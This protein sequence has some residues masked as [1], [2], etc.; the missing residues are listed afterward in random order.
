MAKILAPNIAQNGGRPNKIVVRITRME[1]SEYNNKKKPLIIFY[2]FQETSFGKM[3]VAN[4]RKGICYMGFIGDKKKRTKELE[5]CFPKAL[6]KQ[7]VTQKQKDIIQ[8]FLR[9]WKCISKI[10]LHLKG[11]EFQIKVWKQ[12]LHIPVGKVT[13]YGD[14]AEKVGHPKASRAVGSAVGRNPVIYAIPC[15]RVICANGSLG[16]FYWG[17][18]HK[19]NFLNCEATGVKK[20]FPAKSWDPTFF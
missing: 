5:R 3:I 7:E 18:Q 13:T 8:I 19:I 16:G 10:H 2:S 15:H 11:T 1:P 17:L 4:T 12:L 20:S 9:D 14:I 6:L